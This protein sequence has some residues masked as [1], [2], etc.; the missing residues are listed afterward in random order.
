M[1]YDDLLKTS[2]VKN[3]MF[4]EG[5]RRKRPYYVKSY[6]PVIVEGL[7]ER[8]TNPTPHPFPEM[9]NFQNIFTPIRSHSN[10]RTT[11]GGELKIPL[12]THS[13]Q[14][15]SLAVRSLCQQTGGSQWACCSLQQAVDSFQSILSYYH[16]TEIQIRA[17]SP[18][19]RIISTFATLRYPGKSQLK[20]ERYRSSSLLT[21][22]LVI[23]NK[24]KRSRHMLLM[25]HHHA[26]K[27]NERF[28][29]VFFV[30]F[31]QQNFTVLGWFLPQPPLKTNKQKT[32]SSS[33]KWD[34]QFL[35]KLHM[36]FPAA[37]NQEPLYSPLLHGSSIQKL[38]ILISVTRQK[39][40]SNGNKSCSFRA[41]RK[42]DACH[43]AT[44]T[45]A[46]TPL[47]LSSLWRNTAHP[48]L[49]M[50]F[51]RT[52]LQELSLAACTAY[53]MLRWSST[54]CLSHYRDI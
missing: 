51:C 44:S 33:A 43:L 5:F 3:N 28:R 18:I 47:C 9:N 15:D 8:K 54:E 27:E 7:Q 6:H 12:P 45:A 20:S 31:Y 52:F 39:C 10:V 25:F 48:W 26:R 30:V 46:P 22:P 11:W 23:T 37:A 21:Y 17:F 41:S 16:S 29:Q 40:N 50:H 19:L 34:T 24:G 35:H 4:S 32:C 42:T 36:I 14:Q 2:L 1:L 13:C 49:R 53:L 38:L